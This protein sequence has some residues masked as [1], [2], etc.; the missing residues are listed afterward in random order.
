[1]EPVAIALI[2]AAAFGVAVAV[3]AFVRHLLLS[4]DKRL[5]DMAQ[6]DALEQEA[7]ELEKLRNQMTG[8]QRFDSHYQVLGDNKDA[9]QYIDQKIED[10][11]K[12]KSELI[13]RYAQMTIKES[14]A[15]I[16]GEQSVERKALCDKLKL[17]ID[18]EINFYASE[19]DQLQRR[20]ALLWDTHTDL[21]E[22]LVNQE[23]KRNENLDD[24][25]QRH[26]GLLEKIY[27]RHIEANQAIA[28]QTIESGNQSFKMIIMA[29]IQF[30]MQF[31]GL[32]SGISA[33]QAKKE[34][35]A[36]IEVVEAE[37]EIND[38]ESAGEGI[39]DNSG[40]SVNEERD[41]PSSSNASIPSELTR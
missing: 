29:P 40:V 20:R 2:C 23:I 1:M 12:K 36:R 15:I 31:F 28:G 18:S 34:K 27:L 21:Q 8:N 39:Y 37:K 4:R 3:A 5:N 19:L 24:I 30:L 25:Y 35:E 14:S 26:S 11:L 9:I 10:I 17:E 7:N 33:E 32:S 22:Y 13:H 16:E 38:L 6:H 41:T